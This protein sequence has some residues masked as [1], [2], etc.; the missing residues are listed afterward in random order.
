MRISDVLENWGCVSVT[1]L[2]GCMKPR[3]FLVVPDSFKGTLSAEE[4]AEAIRQGIAAALP[5]AE[6]AC[7][8]LADGGEGSSSIAARSIGGELVELEVVGPEAEPVKGFYYRSADCALIELAAASAFT[9][10]KNPSETAA[11]ATTYGFGQLIAHAIDQGATS[12]RLFLGGSATT[13]AGVGM[14]RALGARFLDAEGKELVESEAP[15][16]FPGEQLESIAS[17]DDSELRKRLAGIDIAA[18]V[19]VDNPLCGA[20]GAAQTYG[21][22]K[23]ADPDTVRFLDAALASFAE[24]VAKQRG[25]DEQKTPGVGAAGG[26]GFGVLTLLEG[27]LLPGSAFFL[28]LI[29]FDQRLGEIDLV[30]TGE[31]KTDWQSLHGKL[32]N[33][34]VSRTAESKTPV[35]GL[36]GKNELDPKE[37]KNYPHTQII[38]ITR[39]DAME[40]AFEALRELA[41][42]TFNSLEIDG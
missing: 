32:L 11:R 24:V 4:A 39:A 26:A 28:D 41:E 42:T 19:D 7:F 23:G 27:K 35:V 34:V 2:W 15:T 6:I 9:Q 30:V 21:P 40:N 37:L 1:Y 31:G 5:E 16:P 10:S 8:P 12:I 13:D 36:C 20:D 14:A 29:E 22:Q 33:E 18:I 25:Q 3:R 17:Y 38:S